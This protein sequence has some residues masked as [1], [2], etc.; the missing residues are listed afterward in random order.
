M[1]DRV[2]THANRTRQP[3][4]LEAKQ[5]LPRLLPE[6]GHGPVD[7]VQVDGIDA[8]LP[9][10]LLERPERSLV[11]VV[12]VPEFRRDEYLVARDLA[13]TDRL[14]YVPLVPVELRGVDQSIPNVE[15]RRDRPLRLLS[16]G[17]P[18]HAEP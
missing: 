13:R 6:P 16:G 10:A 2:V 3:L 9:A 4:L 11:A 14:A 8:E 1:A 5:P 17:G 7:E 12:G 15:G 18:P